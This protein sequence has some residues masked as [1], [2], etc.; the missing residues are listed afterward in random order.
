MEANTRSV[1]CLRIIGD[2]LVP[3]E[4]TKLLGC[5]PTSAEFKGQVLTSKSGRQRTA[6]SGSWRMEASERTP[7]DLNAQVMEILERL[8]TDLEVW[9]SLASRFRMDL[10]CGLFM[11]EQSS[12]FTLS[13]QA[14]LALASRRIEF[15]LCLYGPLRD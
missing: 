12:G 4:I 15:G 5:A 6:R 10:F 14:M 7:D 1:A 13:P 9:A 8:N 11:M 2:D 3:D